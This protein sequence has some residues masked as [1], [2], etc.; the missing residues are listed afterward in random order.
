[1]EQQWHGAHR[2]A[3]AGCACVPTP[4]QQGWLLVVHGRDCFAHRVEYGDNLTVVKPFP[5][6]LHYVNQISLAQVHQ[7]VGF[8]LCAFHAKERGGA[9]GQD[10]GMPSKLFHS[11]DLGL[12]V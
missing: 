9:Q 4:V 7:Q 5:P 11:I 8:L 3:S 6:L 1:M 2:S 10:V 12:A